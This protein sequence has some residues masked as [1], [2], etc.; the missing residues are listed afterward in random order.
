MAVRFSKLKTINLD[1]ADEEETELLEPEAGEMDGLGGEG[2]GV[3]NN[4]SH[5]KGGKGDEGK[6]KLIF[7]E[8]GEEAMEEVK[9]GR[10]PSRMR[11]GSRR[12]YSPVN[13]HR[14]W[15]K[16][17]CN[18]WKAVAIAVLVFTAVFL[19]SLIVSA[20]IPEPSEGIKFYQQLEHVH[21]PCTSI[22]II[23]HHAQ[24]TP[25]KNV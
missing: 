7:G 14:R 24:H 1:N 16:C 11:L 5:R 23:I 12:S 15:R 20:L 3:W 13:K 2:G 22:I 4:V 17:P 6:A 18:S 10:L 25:N 19:I 9:K 21:S 8:D